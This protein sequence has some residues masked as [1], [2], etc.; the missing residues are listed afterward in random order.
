M[1]VVIQVLT[2]SVCLLST[3]V[4][5]LEQSPHQKGISV[6]WFSVAA[7]FGL[8]GVQQREENFSTSQK[9]QK[10]EEMRNKYTVLGTYKQ[11]HTLHC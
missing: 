11:C 2:T 1:V 8:V 6:V 7:K 10:R 9:G 4:R 5:I 3:I